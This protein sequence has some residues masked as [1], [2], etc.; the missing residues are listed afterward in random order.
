MHPKT[1]KEPQMREEYWD[2]FVDIK[3]KECYMEHYRIRNSILDTS[4]TYAG[5]VLSAGGLAAFF[6]Q[7]GIPL[8]GAVL[9]VLG[10]LLSLV[11]HLLPYTR[12][13]QALS[14]ALAD[15]SYLL[16][17]IEVDWRKFE[18]DAYT[19]EELADKLAEQLVAYSDIETKYLCG[20]PL[21]RSKRII[22]TASLENQ[23]FFAARFS[24]LE[25][26]E[27]E[28]SLNLN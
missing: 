10:Q 26:E 24:L 19:D 5:L 20:L 15:L 8:A 16:N 17:R 27:G 11:N 9:I 1:N 6:T 13:T 7:V 23:A 22:K 4:F 2:F 12:R 25:D 21:P 3:F 14:Y 18:L 28:P